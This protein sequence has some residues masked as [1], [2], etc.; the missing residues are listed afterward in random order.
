MSFR[1]CSGSSSASKGS[2]PIDGLSPSE[3]V[4]LAARGALMLART[5]AQ[6]RLPDLDQHPAHGIALVQE[7]QCLCTLLEG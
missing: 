5:D 2:Q 1:P 7:P 3:R 6:L 4:P